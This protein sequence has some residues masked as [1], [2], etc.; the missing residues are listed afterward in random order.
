MN[1]SASHVTRC[2]RQRD[3]FRS[4][5]FDGVLAEQLPQAMQR[6]AER[7]ACA[8]LVELRPKESDEPVSLLE[9]S[10]AREREIQ[11][12]RQGFWLSREVRRRRQARS[13]RRAACPTPE[14]E[15]KPRD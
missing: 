2:R 8:I 10:R 4:T 1:S 9:A 14:V 3:G 5:V 6:T 11:Q 13:L 7:R 15:S 12:Q